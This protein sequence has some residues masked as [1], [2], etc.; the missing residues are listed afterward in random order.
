M[1]RHCRVTMGPITALRDL[2]QLRTRLRHLNMKYIGTAPPPP[3]EN[4]IDPKRLVHLAVY[5]P[6]VPGHAE[7]FL[8]DSQAL[9][10]PVFDDL[11]HWDAA[12][13]WLLRA[14]AATGCGGVPAA[15]S[16]AHESKPAYPRTTGDIIPP[17][18]GAFAERA[19]ERLRNAAL[20]GPDWGI[21][22]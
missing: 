20:D 11:V 3:P 19:D 17:P 9:F 12:L 21:A 7:I 8:R 5:K 1:P 15:H 4:A 18:W 13:E 6:E 14:Q 16:V 2:V 10:E 22:V